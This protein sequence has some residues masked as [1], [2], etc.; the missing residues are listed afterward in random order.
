MEE[1]AAE[2][3]ITVLA[4]HDIEGHVRILQGVVRSEGWE[5]LAAMRVVS[6][7]EVGLPANVS[8]RVAWRFAQSNR[9]VLLT[10]N[11]NQSGHDSLEQTIDEEN[12]PKAL[13]VLTISRLDRLKEPGYRL[14]CAARIIDI[15]SEIERYSDVGRI[16]IP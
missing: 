11:R 6:F 3:L 14:R 4:D 2:G 15:V 1:Q 8:D 5:S 9:M 12:G 10:G 13:P 7:V 16:F